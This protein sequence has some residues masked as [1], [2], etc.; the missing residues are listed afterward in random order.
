MISEEYV[1]SMGSYFDGVKLV[2]KRIKAGE[3]LIL[4]GLDE[5]DEIHTFLE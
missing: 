4:V 3:L 1:G 2:L 5:R